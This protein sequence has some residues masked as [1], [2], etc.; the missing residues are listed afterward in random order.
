MGIVTAKGSLSEVVV[1]WA[2]IYFFC[3]GRLVNS[4]YSRKTPR[5]LTAPVYN[6]QQYSKLPAPLPAPSHPG[7]NPSLHHL[8]NRTTGHPAG[9]QQLVL[10]SGSNTAMSPYLSHSSTVDPGSP[11][12][13]QHQVGGV[14]SGK[15][16]VSV[17]DQNAGLSESYPFQ[18]GAL[19]GL[20][21]HG[22]LGDGS[23]DGTSSPGV[24][25]E[26]GHSSDGSRLLLGESPDGSVGQRQQSKFTGI[27]MRDDTGTD[28]RTV[29]SGNILGNAGWMGNGSESRA[30]GS[31]RVMV[32][33]TGMKLVP[34]TSNTSSSVSGLTMEGS[35]W[36]P[37]L[38]SLGDFTSSGM[39][40]QNHPVQTTF[41]ASVPAN[42]LPALD[43][44]AIFGTHSP[45][46]GFPHLPP[47]AGGS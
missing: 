28:G 45:S 1:Y 41:S 36:Q 7:V 9:G 21:P 5:T 12:L 29:A 39:I 20:L 34:H 6:K 38:N 2:Y 30:E 22:L 18:L 47:S 3:T 27:R 25:D 33:N 17:V 37:T 44:D 23:S 10:G 13:Y 32:L 16:S 46:S 35:S 26:G 42:P 8:L 14:T 19:D 15:D 31:G 24:Y 11:A 43:M 4:L 40:S